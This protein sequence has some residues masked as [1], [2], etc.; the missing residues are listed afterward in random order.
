MNFIMVDI[1]S[2]VTYFFIIRH[3]PSV[4]MMERERGRER[5]REREREPQHKSS[6]YLIASA[7]SLQTHTHTH[8]AMVPVGWCTTQTFV[9]GIGILVVG[10]GAMYVVDPVGSMEIAEISLAAP[11]ART[12]I[13]AMYGG[14]HLAL[15][16]FL[17]YLVRRGGG[18]RRHSSCYAGCPRLWLRG[19][20]PP[21]WRCGGG[22]SGPL[23]RGGH[24]RRVSSVRCSCALLP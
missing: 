9:T 10:V 17:F 21:S 14:L 23:Q 8:T 1:T 24:C 16:A 19:C 3:C 13:R 18:C 7:F 4:E 12:E 20:V 5:E 15:G 2:L 11:A 22:H 6:F